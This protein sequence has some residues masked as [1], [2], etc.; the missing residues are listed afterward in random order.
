MILMYIS[1]RCGGFLKYLSLRGSQENNRSKFSHAL[2]FP[3]R[4]LE[5][6]DLAV[7]SVFCCIIR[8]TVSNSYL[9]V[10]K[11]M[12]TT[13]LI[14]MVHTPL[15]LLKKLVDEGNIK[16]TSS[17]KELGKYVKKRMIPKPPKI[18]NLKNSM[19]KRFPDIIKFVNC[20]FTSRV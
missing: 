19:H 6:V 15:Y 5:T 1:Q 7:Y 3:I 11:Q 2:T 18:N 9:G 12:L 8:S 13:K 20:N 16:G 4:E 14:S 17:L 10:Q